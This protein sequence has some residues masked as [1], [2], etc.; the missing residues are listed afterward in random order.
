MVS[1]DVLTTEVV[2]ERVSS[3]RMAGQ[4][5]GRSRTGLSGPRCSAV[6]MSGHSE[7]IEVFE[8]ME[9]VSSKMSGASSARQ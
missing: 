4:Q 1:D 3:W 7:R 2:V 6:P 8:E 5:V 9:T